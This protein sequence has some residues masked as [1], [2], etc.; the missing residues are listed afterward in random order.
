V[1]DT[2][3]EADETFFVRLQSPVNA[4]L[5]N[6]TATVTIL[7]DDD[8]PLLTAP[9][10]LRKEGNAGLGK[11]V[12][13]FRLSAPSGR[14]ITVDYA[15]VAGT[16]LADVDFLPTNGVITF[17]AGKTTAKV[18]VLVPGDKSL[19]T[20]ETFYLAL[21]NP[22]N[23]QLATNAIA[24]TI[25]NNDP[26]PKA[27]VDDA[28]LVEGGGPANVNVR[29]R[30]ATSSE[31]PVTLEFTTTNGTAVAG[32]DYTAANGLITFAPGETNQTIALEVLG[33]DL[34][35]PL[36]YFSVRLLNPTNAIIA[37]GLARVSLT[38]DDVTLAGAGAILA[39]GIPAAIESESADPP[40]QLSGSLAADAVVLTFLGARGG[41]Y[42]IETTDRLESA[43]AS[44]QAVDGNVIVGTGAVM[45]IR[46]PRGA[47]PAGRFYRLRELPEEKN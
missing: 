29:I 27:Y 5:G 44:W 47:A 4:T 19:E 9:D 36:E 11:A 15:T 21:S 13:R 45:T 32:S 12:F 7:N 38:N 18:T 25:L 23:V 17:A 3:N 31:L 24:C 42:L 16:A 30:L 41:R 1:G 43:P 26:P 46:F 35:E 40:L 34:V 2:R 22:V 33:E 20:N 28:G 6:D 10:V 14:P 37:R 39:A 8:L